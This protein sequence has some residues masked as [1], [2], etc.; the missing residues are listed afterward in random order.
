[1]LK[2]LDRYSTFGQKISSILARDSLKFNP[3]KLTFVLGGNSGQEAVFTIT[4]A[5]SEM[6]KLIQGIIDL[7]RL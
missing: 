4:F 5:F 3:S 1:V 7:L 6:P 2:K